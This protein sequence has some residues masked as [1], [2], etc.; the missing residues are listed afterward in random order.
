MEKPRRKLRIVFIDYVLEPDKPGI[1]GLSDL[2]WDMATELVNIGHDVHIVA[3][4]YTHVYPDNRVIVHNFKTPPIGYRNAIGQ[5]LILYRASKIVKTLDADIVHAPEYVSTAVLGALAY[6]KPMIVT[7][8]GNIYQQ[9]RHHGYNGEWYYYQ[10]LKWALKTSIKYCDVIIASST[11]LKRLWEETGS[12]PNKT[13]YIPLGVNA[14]RF[15][16]VPL[17]RKKL[18]LPAEKLIFLYVGRFSIEKGIGDLLEAFRLAGL[19]QYEDRVQ[20]IFIGKGQIASEIESK[21]Q[22]SGLN[23]IVTIIDWVDQNQLSLW[24]SAAD[25][26]F[27]PSWFEAFGRVLTEAFICGTP[28]IASQTGA[29]R[30]H[31][32]D[33][34]TGFSFPPQDKHALAEI[35]TTI[36]THPQL[37]KEMR[38]AVMAYTQGNLNWTRIMERILE[39]VYYPVIAHH[40][41]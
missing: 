11:E 32:V 15:S 33:G 6:K 31:I 7:P 35:L 5:L 21:L 34:K 29:A 27:L 4:Y 16:F 9:I 3:S 24:Y 17:A 23:K 38:P 8:P 37:L 40:E 22:A 19:S 39:E 2:V 10:I 25:A 14:A 41:R 30:D 12:D 20:I 18:N 26:L 13:I 36:I 28:V 1:T